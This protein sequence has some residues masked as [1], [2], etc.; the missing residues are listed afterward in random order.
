LKAGVID[1]TPVFVTT[2]FLAQQE[3]QSAQARGDIAL[4]LI[5]VYRAL[6]GGWE[7]RLNETPAGNDQ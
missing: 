7:L 5:G 6:G 3:I 2:Q 4:G 1:L